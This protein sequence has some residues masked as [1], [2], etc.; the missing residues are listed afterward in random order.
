[1]KRFLYKIV[2]VINVL[3]VLAVMLT[4]CVRARVYLTGRWESE[5]PRMYIDCGHEKVGLLWNADG[6]VTKIH[7]QYLG[8]S[9]GI[10]SMETEEDS[11][12]IYWGTQSLKGNTLIM[13]LR[14]GGRIVMRRVGP[15]TVD[16]KEYP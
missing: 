3:I 13:D 14:Y 7:I 9:F 1:M 11:K 6:T 15:A 10:G 2:T 4:S 8:G 5:Y 16:G 12:P